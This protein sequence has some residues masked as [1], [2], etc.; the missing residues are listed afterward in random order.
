MSEIATPR[1]NYG[2]VHMSIKDE[3]LAV[4]SFYDTRIKTQGQGQARAFEFVQDR[5]NE[6]RQQVCESRQNL[7]ILHREFVENLRW[8]DVTGQTQ[9]V[10]QRLFDSPRGSMHKFDGR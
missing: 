5:T 1:K 3:L 2:S 8:G 10:Y 9:F 4:L 6:D 7:P